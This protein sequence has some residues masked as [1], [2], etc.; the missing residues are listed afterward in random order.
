V[1]KCAGWAIFTSIPQPVFAVPAFLLVLVF[2][3]LLPFGLGFAGG[4]M[5]FLVASELMPEAIANATKSETAW[6][7]M[8]GLVLMLLFTSGL[9]L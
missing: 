9:G 8:I 7:F 2:Q 5:L 3:P 4:A 6:G 1:W